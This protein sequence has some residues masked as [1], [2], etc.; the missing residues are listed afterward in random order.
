M[1]LGTY[2]LVGGMVTSLNN[3][4][5]TANNMANINTTAFKETKNTV[6]SFNSYL[7]RMEKNGEEPNSELTVINTIP[8]IKTGF[9]NNSVG[10]IQV[11]SNPLDFAIT[12]KDIYF[13]LED[14]NNNIVFTRDGSFKNLDGYL[15]NADG[16][17]VLTN[18]NE[19]INSNTTDL[20]K[21]LGLIKS[22]AE[23]FEI[24]GSNSYKIKDENKIEIIENQDEYIVSNSLE[25]SNINMIKSMVEM[26][27]A[28]RSY[29]QMQK[30]LHSLGELD[31]ESLKIGETKV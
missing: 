2:S 12:E 31:T 20:T 24:I 29:E 18:N 13:K 17:K 21:K 10:S 7:Q 26:I 28:Q 4:D 5:I 1:N 9:Q 22:K 23:N 16:L 3:L 25:K 15:V 27:D 19:Y 14:K 8:Q 6:G 11:T 30:G